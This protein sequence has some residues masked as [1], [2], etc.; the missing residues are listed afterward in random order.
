MIFALIFLTALV[1]SFIT[2]VIGA[3]FEDTQVGQILL[4]VGIMIFVM[5]IIASITAIYVYLIEVL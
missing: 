5:T 2:M 4:F 3:V 1:V